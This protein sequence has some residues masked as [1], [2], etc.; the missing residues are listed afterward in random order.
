MAAP[1]GA[2][3]GSRPLAGE[4]RRCSRGELLGGDPIGVGRVAAST[5]TVIQAIRKA[6]LIG[7]GGPT[8]GGRRPLGAGG[9]DMTGYTF[10]AL[11]HLRQVGSVAKVG[12]MRSGSTSGWQTIP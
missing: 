2:S 10:V 8:G 12:I 3:R 4:R 7:R 5:V 11:M 1:G 9:V 6:A